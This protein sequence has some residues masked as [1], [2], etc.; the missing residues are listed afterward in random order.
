ML[1][2]ERQRA[3]SP[4]ANSLALVEREQ[5][6]LDALGAQVA[7]ARQRRDA[8]LAILNGAMHRAGVTC[9]VSQAS[10]NVIRAARMGE[11]AAVIAHGASMMPAD[12]VPR[13]FEET[14]VA[15]TRLM[16]L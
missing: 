2:P 4:V 7:D 10:G 15:A 14:R 8:A 1:S 11:P 6:R 16:A 3:E 12:A 5:A 13:G 9:V